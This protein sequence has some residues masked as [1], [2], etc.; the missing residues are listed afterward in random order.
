[1]AH[2]ILDESA[3]LA[4]EIANGNRRARRTRPSTSDA[5]AIVPA[6]SD[7]G[8]IIESV[9]GVD[10]RSINRADIW[11]IN[12]VNIRSFIGVDIWSINRADIGSINRADIKSIY[13]SDN[14][15]ENLSN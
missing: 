15:S 9:V 7:N 8:V 14:A 4:I 10:N 11:S 6:R 2:L 3:K 12:R 5:P 13:G 1:M